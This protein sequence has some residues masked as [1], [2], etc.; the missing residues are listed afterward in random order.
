MSAFQWVCRRVATAGRGTRAAPPPRP[1]P[2][3]FLLLFLLLL[4]RGPGKRQ[5]WIPEQPPLLLLA[6]WL[7]S[8]LTPAVQPRLAAPRSLRSPKVAASRPPTFRLWGTEK[9]M[10]AF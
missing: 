10:C 6:G 7:M 2:T 1:P 9:V 8:Q 3:P 4:L 5:G